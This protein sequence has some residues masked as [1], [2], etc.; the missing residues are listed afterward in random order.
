VPPDLQLTYIE[1]K[2]AYVFVCILTN[3]LTAIVRT[4]SAVDR[5]GMLACR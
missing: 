2:C 4:D 5:I 3:A 1:W